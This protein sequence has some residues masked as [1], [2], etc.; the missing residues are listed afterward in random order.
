MLPVAFTGRFACSGDY[1]NHFETKKWRLPSVLLIS[2]RLNNRNSANEE[3]NGHYE[4]RTGD[5][6][7]LDILRYLSA[8]YKHSPPRDH[9]EEVVGVATPPP[10]PCKTTQEMNIIQEHGRYSVHDY[11]YVENAWYM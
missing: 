5:R 2:R 3:Q 4:E 6:R 7:I 11:M 8:K 9:L 10:Q 1:G